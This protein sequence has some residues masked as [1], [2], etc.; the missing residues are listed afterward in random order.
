[1][2]GSAGIAN[3][4]TFNFSFTNENGPVAG[5]VTGT[6]TLPDGDGTFAA[7]AITV[8][9]APAALGYTTPLSANVATTLNTFQVVGGAIVKAASAF[10]T[11]SLGGTLSP[12][13]LSSP[14]GTLL[15]TSGGGNPTNGVLDS[16]NSSLTYTASTPEPT[17]VITLIGVGVLGVA[18]KKLKKKA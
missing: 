8:T 1:M 4:A 6:I 7:T 9:S 15:G 11:G 18:S 2:L 5:T 13:G 10:A 17:S 14:A 3:A 16:D 12:F